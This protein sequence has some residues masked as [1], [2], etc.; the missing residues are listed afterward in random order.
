MFLSISNIIAFFVGSFCGTMGILFFSN[1]KI[2]H[3][4]RHKSETT[5]T[6]S[7]LEKLT[8]EE[9]ENV[10]ALVDKMIGK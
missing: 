3:S 10:K 7:P 8:K 2:K 6:A 9:Q 4:T 1:Y 5:F